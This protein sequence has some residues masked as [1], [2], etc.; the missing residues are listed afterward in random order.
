MSIVYMDTKT[1]MKKFIKE[2]KDETILEASYIIASNRIK[3]GTKYKDQIM[4]L[5]Y[6][7]DDCLMKLNDEKETKSKSNSEYVKAYFKM[8]N[9]NNISIASMIKITLE[10]NLTTIILTTPLEDKTFNHMELLKEYIEKNFK[11]KIVRYKSGMSLDIKQKESNKTILKTCADVISKTKKRKK[12]K[13]MK[14][15]RG[16]K[17]YFSELGKKRLQRLLKK[18]GLYLDGMSESEMIDIAMTFLV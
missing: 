1:F 5:F 10:N 16:Q 6:V 7:P 14:T 13:Q 15:H 12:E 3:F 4:K 9:R 2:Q 18:N 8:L 11:Y 17:Q